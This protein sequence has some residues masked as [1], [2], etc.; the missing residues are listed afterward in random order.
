MVKA[1]Q[2][3]WNVD[4]NQCVY[5]QVVMYGTLHIVTWP[6]RPSVRPIADLNDFEEMMLSLV[7]P[8]VQV[9]TIPTTGELAFAGHVC[10]FRQRVHE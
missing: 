10:N 8:F 1:R 7:H 6:A 4:V 2:L 3:N 5:V 9:Y